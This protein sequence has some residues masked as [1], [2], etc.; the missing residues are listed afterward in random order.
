MFALLADPFAGPKACERA[1]AAQAF[2]RLAVGAVGFD[3]RGGSEVS[4]IHNKPFVP[5]RRVSRCVHEWK[6]AEP[7]AESAKVLTEAIFAADVCAPGC[8]VSVR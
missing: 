8:A 6:R 3:G 7:I 1:L 4:I 5:R 2:A